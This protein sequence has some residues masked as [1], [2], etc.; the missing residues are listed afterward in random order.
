M[1]TILWNQVAVTPGGDA[2]GAAV[3]QASAKKFTDLKLERLQ[4]DDLDALEVI[5][6]WVQ[7]SGVWEH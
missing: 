3:P 7:H 6:T 2:P 4:R 5:A 1:L